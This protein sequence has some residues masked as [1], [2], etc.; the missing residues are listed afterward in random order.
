MAW[1]C[2]SNLSS[3][4]IANEL[5]TKNTNAKNM[6]EAKPIIKAG[7][8]YIATPS[9]RMEPAKKAIIETGTTFF[10]IISSRAL[11]IAAFGEILFVV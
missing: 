9:Y 8:M 10:K 2:F 7:I 5:R 6:T 4:H 3:F 1:D 11:P